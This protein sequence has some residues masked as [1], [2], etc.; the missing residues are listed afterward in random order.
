MNKQVMIREYKATDIRSCISHHTTTYYPNAIEWFVKC[1][2]SS[3]HEII[4]EPYG[5]AVVKKS[6]S[7]I[8]TLFVY[9]DYRNRG[10]GLK[11]FEKCFAIL[12]TRKP[13]LTVSEENHEQFKKIFDHYG[14][15]LTCE[16]IGM[17]REGKKEFVYNG[18]LLHLVLTY[19]WYDETVNGRKRTEYRAMT[20]KWKKQIWDKRDEYT[21]I[22]F[23][24]GYT[25]EMRVFSF[26][27]VDIGDCPIEGWDEEYYRIK[28]R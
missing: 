16:D 3:D 25:S 13:L 24:R 26:E 10:Y 1:E 9:D 12:G 11:L 6:E 5:F 28:F 4:E 17:Y 14:F 8:C 2:S 22:R 18:K 27:G 19:Y 23:A 21:H 7:K 15:E 20:E